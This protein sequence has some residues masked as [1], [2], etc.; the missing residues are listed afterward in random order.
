MHALGMT[1]QSF[2]RKIKLDFC[3][4]FIQ[5]EFQMDQTLL[6]KIEI[7]KIPEGSWEIFKNKKL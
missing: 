7:I 2:R 6:V 3:L 1:V 4:C 5:N